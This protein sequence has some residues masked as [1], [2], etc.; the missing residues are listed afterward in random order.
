MSTVDP[1][2][3]E[4]MG[5]HFGRYNRDAAMGR[6]AASTR[7]LHQYA[8]STLGPRVNT[9]R[10]RSDSPWLPP[11]CSIDPI[12]VTMATQGRAKAM[13]AHY[14]WLEMREAARICQMV[15]RGHM[16]V[17]W[18]T[19]QMADK[20]LDLRQLHTPFTLLWSLNR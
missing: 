5:R 14:A 8:T 6:Y 12:L 17:P 4:A 2:M 20:L 7:D 10:F 19:T 15:E 3:Y 18:L 11:G 9:G 16:A 1:A 13:T